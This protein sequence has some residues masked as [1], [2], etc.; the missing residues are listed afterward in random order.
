MN[1]DV[2]FVAAR[3]LPSPRQV[4]PPT[5]DFTGRTDDLDSLLGT[6]NEAVA[7]GGGGVSVILG[8]PSG[9]GK[10]ALGRK[11]AERLGAS[12]WYATV[13]MDLQGFSGRST[14]ARATSKSDVARHILRAFRDIGE[15]GKLDDAA[16]QAELQTLFAEIGMCGKRVL[17]F[18]DNVADA[19]QVRDLN[20]PSNSVTIITSRRRLALPG[21][22]W[23]PIGPMPE[24][25][26]VELLTSLCS[27]QGR[28]VD[29][30]DA[31]GIVNLCGR[32]PQAIRLAAGA[33]ATR[34]NLTPSD[35]QQRL[36]S[37]AQRISVLDQFVEE[38]G[39]R[40]LEASMLATESVL[41]PWAG[42]L[43]HL[44][45]LFAGDFEQESAACLWALAREP[46]RCFAI[47]QANAE[48]SV[49]PLGGSTVMRTI[50]EHARVDEA[51]FSQIGAMLGHLVSMSAIDYDPESKRYRFHDIIRSFCLRRLIENTAPEEYNACVVTYV[52][53]MS[54][55]ARRCGVR[56]GAAQSAESKL[57]FF[58]DF[59]NVR[60]AFRWAAKNLSQEW[61]KY[62]IINITQPTPHVLDAV[63]SPKERV[64]WY[65]E[66]VR[67]AEGLGDKRSVDVAKGQL[68]HDLG[69]DEGLDAAKPLWDEQL[70][71]TRA[72]GDLDSEAITLGHLGIAFKNAGRL[73][74]ALD[75]HTKRLEISKRLRA[76]DPKH[77]DGLEGA[78]LLDLANVTALRDGPA[79]ASHEMLRAVRAVRRGGRRS[80]EESCLFRLSELACAT[81]KPFRALVFAVRQRKI[82]DEIGS[83]NGWVHATYQCAR[84]CC[85]LGRKS[86]ALEH[87]DE[88]ISAGAKPSAVR[89]LKQRILEGANSIPSIADS[90]LGS[91]GKLELGQWPEEAE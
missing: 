80:D 38:T 75:C 5:P 34:P 56:Y 36:E 41:E 74:E 31:R 19:S 48:W 33:L 20:P 68:A 39:E 57:E 65:R 27:R 10:T 43:W 11:F 91:N 3:E 30:E 22:S 25:E 88:L 90:G 81:N 45:S 16:V 71:Q 9:V 28:D 62:A 21:T 61:A 63:L 76:T 7:A 72:D 79:K 51:M 44:L 69:I 53:L 32:F 12:G 77:A 23:H 73:D 49:N 2:T 4:P 26:A 6:V 55:F 87:L 82:A 64:E 67:A 37:I 1:G 47:S 8:G 14:S 29:E 42:A 17:F 59:D 15:I 54:E 58:F 52:M 24:G 50:R 86:A 60:D 13:Y 18:W 35:F 70:R 46:Q 78:A 89:F 40:G 85:S 84:S 66:A 83:L